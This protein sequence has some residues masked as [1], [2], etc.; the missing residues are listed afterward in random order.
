MLNNPE[1]NNS[2]ETWS[3]ILDRLNAFEES[4][5]IINSF[6]DQTQET[7]PTPLTPDTP[8][9]QPKADSSEEIREL[10]SRLKDIYQSQEAA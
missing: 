4:L 3:A 2:T 10:Q 9:L 5:K 7:A 6:P 8:K 1:L